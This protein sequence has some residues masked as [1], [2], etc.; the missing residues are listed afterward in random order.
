[1]TRPLTH[2]QP[3]NEDYW[4]KEKMMNIQIRE[5]EARADLAG[6]Q[7]REAKARADLVELELNV[8]REEARAKG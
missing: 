4:F 5:H 7:A 2:H 1:M 6:H 3:T 8:R